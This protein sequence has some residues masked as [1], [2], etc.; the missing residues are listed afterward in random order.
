MPSERLESRCIARFVS[1]NTVVVANRPRSR[2]LF[3]GA[4]G[5]HVITAAIRAA[6][7]DNVAM[8][9]CRAVGGGNNAHGLWRRAWRRPGRR[10]AALLSALR[11]ASRLGLRATRA[12]SGSVHRPRGHRRHLSD[13]LAFVRNVFDVRWLPDCSA[14]GTV[15][16]APMARDAH[17]LGLWFSD[18]GVGSD[19]RR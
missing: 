6:D 17:A 9:I 16:A 18:S 3:R 5:G 10:P 7:G 13:F 2:F 8:A 12:V 14:G 1:P 15:S 11:T 19:G 4:G